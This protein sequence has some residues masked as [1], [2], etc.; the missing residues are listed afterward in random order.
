M[1][2]H[3][4][5]RSPAL[6]ALVAL[7]AGTALV[8]SGARASTL[9]GA[10]KTVQALYYNGVL[11][12]PEMELPVGGSTS[13]PTSLA[14]AV[15][16]QQGSGSGSTIHVGDTQ[17]VI[18]NL[19][20]GFPF[21]FLNTP[22]ST[23]TDAIDGFD[24]KFTGEAIV[25]VSVDP[26]SAVAFLPVS[27][28]FQGNTHLGLQLISPNE[29]RIDVTGDLPLRDDQLIIDVS[30]AIVTGATPLP[31]AFPLFATGLGLMG[32]FARRRKRKSSSASAVAG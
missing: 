26:A 8:S 3:L 17:I 13:D 25:S 28:T 6:L 30:N 11:A 29:I 20:S 18:T 23:C 16:Y 27:G 24:F 12:S 32:V 9:L 19:L 2:K 7:L 14:A 10:G 31:A 4:R 22:G 21:C 15:D 5:T 1:K